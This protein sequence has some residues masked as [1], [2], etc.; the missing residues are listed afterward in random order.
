MSKI[1]SIKWN[2]GAHIRFSQK[3]APTITEAI[4]TGMYTL[5]FFMGNPQSLKRQRITDE[6]I[7][8]TQELTKKF[9]MS[10]YTH[11]PYVANFAGKSAP[12]GLAW[13]GNHSVDGYVRSMLK[14]LEY[15]LSVMAQVGHGVVIHPGSNPNRQGGLEA[16]SKS[17]NKINFAPGSQVLLENCAGEGNKLCRDFKEIKTVLDGIDEDNLPNVGICVDTAHIWGQGDYDLRSIDEVER[18][19]LDFDN[20]IGLENF[21]LLHLND[22]EVPLGSKKDRHACLGEGYIWKDSFDSLLYLLNKCKKLDIPAVLE[23]NGYDMITLGQLS[24]IEDDEIVCV[25]V[26]KVQDCDCCKIAA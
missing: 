17:M 26:P 1:Y 9:P 12:D 11:F 3:I 5:Q 22:S 7:K 8:K 25:G 10:I 21:R 14:E 4:N 24:E 2:V 20:I 23:T 15:E 13:S 6:D 19:F 18:M 16:I